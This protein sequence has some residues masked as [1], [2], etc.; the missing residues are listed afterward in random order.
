M[1]ARAYKSFSGTESQ[2]DRIY[3][4]G[5]PTVI[6]AHFLPMTSLSRENDRAK[7]ME[8]I[9]QIYEPISSFTLDSNQYRILTSVREHICQHDPL[10]VYKVIKVISDC[11]KRCSHSRRVHDT[12]HKSEV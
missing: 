9:S 2:R 1:I 11:D 6:V 4:C 12:Q 10:N 7:P 8:M 5:Y 3:M